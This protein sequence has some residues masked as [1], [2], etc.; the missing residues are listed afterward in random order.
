MKKRTIKDYT[1]IGISKPLKRRLIAQRAKY[2]FDDWDS[3]LK[4]ISKMLKQFEP[5]LEDLK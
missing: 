2:G 1:S 3:F 4:V 5:E